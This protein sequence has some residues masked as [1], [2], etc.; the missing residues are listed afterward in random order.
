MLNVK[1]YSLLIVGTLL[2]ALAAVYSAPALAQDGAS[3]YKIGV[4]NM[5]QCLQEYNKREAKYKELEG[6]VTKRQNDIIVPLQNKVKALG[7]QYKNATDSEERTRIE[8]Q[9]NRTATELQ[10][11]M[12]IQQDK[13][14]RLEEQTL[15]ELINDVKSVV[16]AIAAAENY[17]L[18]LDSG[19]A[20]GAVVFSTKTIDITPQVVLQLNK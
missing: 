15:E 5:R 16:D 17:H 4:V 3:G 20:T 9:H 1:R 11:E 12:R 2:A 8:E 6:E 10:S 14:D 7:E 19:G 18:I 13:I